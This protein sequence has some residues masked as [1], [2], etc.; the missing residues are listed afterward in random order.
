MDKQALIKYALI[1]AG[2]LLVLYVF[3]RAGSSGSTSGAVDVD[4]QYSP[5]S[6]PGA[7]IAAKAS[8]FSELVGLGGQVISEGSSIEQARMANMT[9]RQI[10]TDE[11]TLSRYALD[12]EAAMGRYD[13]DTSRAIEAMRIAGAQELAQA[14]ARAVNTIAYDY[15]K[16]DVQRQ[17]T[18]LNA[19]TSIWGTGPTYPE[20]STGGATGILGAIGGIV[21]GLAGLTNPVSRGGG[22]R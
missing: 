6:D 14:Q 15:R 20:R 2:V 17:A 11:T 4:V 9:A 22:L 19:L 7:S 21:Q 1:G 18:I 10:S 3:S 8:A 5:T 16:S 13:L 12:V